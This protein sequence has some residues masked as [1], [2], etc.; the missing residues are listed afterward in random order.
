MEEWWG[1]TDVHR[2]FHWQQSIDLSSAFTASAIRRGEEGGA[3]LGCATTRHVILEVTG[4]NLMMTQASPRQQTPHGP[5][6]EPWHRP[7]SKR[8]G[9]CLGSHDFA[10]P[11]CQV[12]AVDQAQQSGK[13]RPFAARPLQCL[14]K[15]R[16]GGLQAKRCHR[17]HRHHQQGLL[18]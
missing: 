8:G 7:P 17:C 12:V 3:A 10:R 5:P 2:T 13:S 14:Q 4:S 15:R 9:W 18:P 16:G 6:H 1:S 11:A